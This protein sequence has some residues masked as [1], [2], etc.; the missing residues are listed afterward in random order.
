MELL[1]TKFYS[2]TELRQITNKKSKKDIIKKLTQYHY[3][4]QWVNRQG[5][6]ITKT[7]DISTLDLL[8]EK[9]IQYFDEETYQYILPFAA[10]AF[11]SIENEQFQQKPIK[12]KCGFRAEFNQINIS[13]EDIIY[14]TSL[15]DKMNFITRDDLVHCWYSEL[16]KEKSERHYVYQE[17]EIEKAQQWF[18]DF[19]KYQ[20]EA[21]QDPK[22]KNKFGYAAK[23]IAQSTNKL[24]CKVDGSFFMNKF[25]EDGIP[26]Q[27]VKCGNKYYYKG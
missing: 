23:K 24:Y 16:N 9:I 20:E 17:E 19:Q 15:L 13:D 3:E 1:D 7:S 18:N 21:K 26:E 14:Y 27:Y 8:H 5:A 22:I 6:Q 11:K 25:Q 12:N 4:F 2:L 10:I